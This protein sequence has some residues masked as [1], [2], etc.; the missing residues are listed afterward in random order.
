MTDAA[1]LLPER[2]SETDAERRLREAS[3]LLGGTTAEVGDK[4]RGLLDRQKRLEREIDT[5]KSRVA[6]GAT[7]DLAA[8]AV[9]VDG[10][11]VLAARL[12]GLDAKA[13]RDAMDR[14]RQQL[15]DAAILLAGASDGKASLVAGMAGAA[16]G[17]LK[18]GEL[19]AFVA[20]RIGGKG[21]G[22]PDMAQGG[23]QD[24]PELTQALA[25]V[26]AW[27]ASKLSAG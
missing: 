25:E 24:G 19:V 7:A 5:L 20:G 26:P 8:H 15:G 27:V 23:G 10:I 3:G 16:N 21:G 17:R 9:E 1:S 6:S 11:K 12:E 4:L 18:A 14:L 2:Q 13:L 22:R